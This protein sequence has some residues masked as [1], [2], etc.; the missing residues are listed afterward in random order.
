M[1][2]LTVVILAAGQGTR[3]RSRRA[4]DAARPLRAPARRLADRRRAGGRGRPDRRRRLARRTRSTG[5]C[6]TGSRRVVQPEPD[7]TGGAVQAAA[8]EIDD[9]ATVV[10][11]PGDAPLITARGDRAA[12][13]RPRRKRRRRDDG[14]DASSTTRPATAASSATPTA[15]VERVVETKADGDATPEQLAI[16]EVNTGDLRVRR[17]RAERTRSPQLT[18]DNA[19]HE[20]YL[21][22]VLPALRSRRATTSPR[23]SSTTPTS[24]SASTTA[25]SSPRSA[26]SPSGASTTPTAAPA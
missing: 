2:A 3:M 12:R 11:L 14:D 5:S 15:S 19:Q 1:P 9:G 4:E 25:S 22:D 20:L 23:T 26:R 21:P 16:H 7:G 10:V 13:R 18:P 24:R 8:S 6:P 17:R